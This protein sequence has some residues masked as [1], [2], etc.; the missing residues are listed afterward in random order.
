MSLTEQNIAD[1]LVSP[2]DLADEAIALVQ[3]WL[4]E[5]RDEP[6]DVSAQRLAGVLRDPHGLDF[7]VGFVDGVVRPEDLRVAARNLAALTP[8]IPGFLPLHLKAAIRLGAFA[9]PILPQVVVPAARMALRSMVRHLIVDATDRKL[10]DAISSI[11]GRGDGIR[12]NVNLLGEAILG[13]KEAARRLEGTRKLLARD[14]V[15]YVSIKVSSTVA[16]HTPWAFDAAVADAVSALRPLYRVAKETGTFLNLDMEEF[17]DLDLTLAVFETLLGEPE[18]HGVEAGIVLQAYLPDAL[19]AMIRLQEWTAARVASGGAPIKVRVVKGANLPMERVDADVHD[20]PLATWPSKQATDASYKAV[21]DYALRPEHTVNVRIGVAGHN[22]FDIALAWL[23]A[24]RRGVTAAGPS[25]QAG[26]EV[27]MLLGMATAQQT[28]VRRTV[29]SIL[30]YTPVVHPQEFDV[31]IAYLIR[32]LEEGAS[33]ENFMSA[34]FDLDTH[35]ALFARE[36]DRF[37]ASLADMPEGV[38]ASNRVQDRTA[39]AASAPTRGFRNTPDSDPAIEANRGWAA[40]IVARMQGSEL[41]RRTIADHTLTDEAALNELIQDAADAAAAWRALGAAGR[42]EILHRAGDVLEARRADLLEV[43]GAECGKVIEQSDPEV[44]EAIDFAHY[45]AEQALALEAVDG[46]TF[47]PVGVTVVA[48]PWNFPVAIPAGSTLAALAAGSAV[49]IKPAGLAERCGAVMVEALWE[50]G[51]PREVLKLVQVSEN[52]L[53]RQLLTHPAVERVVL[54]GAYE[55]AEL[56]RSFRPDL[57]LLAETSG[58]NAVIVTPSADLDLAAKDVAMSAF[59]HAGQKCSAASLV[60]LVGSVARSRRFRDQ[61]VDAVTSLEVGMPWDEASRV[62]PLIEPAQGKLLRALTSLEPGQRW[63]VEPQRLDADGMLWRPGIREG[64]QPGSEFHRTEYFGPVLGIMTAE[65]LDEAIDIVNAIEYGLTSGLHA[66]DSSEI[67]TWLARIEAGNVY[68]NRGTTGAIVQRQPFG[69]W[70]KSAVGAG[71]KAGGPHYLFGFGSWTDADASAP[72]TP[73]A[74]A[75]PALVAVPAADRDWLASA[76]ASDAAAWASEFSLARDVTGLESEQNV[77]RYASVPV[78]VRLEDASSSALVRVVAAGVRAGSAVT[79]SSA[80]ELPPAVRAWLEG[81]GVRSHVEDA[82]EWGR[83][84][85]RLARTG[86]RVRLL[87]GSARV[88]AEATGGSPSVAVYA[89]EVTRAGHVELLP[90]L[91]E[92]AVSITAHRFGTPR[93]YEVPPLVAA[94]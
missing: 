52:D 84:A 86:G 69:G 16:P 83:R 42:A 87:G 80:A 72:R 25:G 62:G 56:F 43:M 19:A 57:P 3:R 63:V 27:E 33:S 21:L 94:R 7:T 61:L 35:A 85:A 23:L 76:L 18:F 29:G 26:I 70:K 15:D 73:D 41:G 50:A 75:A 45:Y 46:A 47:T 13:K 37:L 2:H 91:R 81:V 39:P 78:T 5:S 89:G 51:V 24:E 66:L 71:T 38:P 30:L 88:V 49:V 6:V 90:F 60:V 59:G 22:L 8:L 92:Q 14:D 74:L 58:K 10:G 65:T 12:L 68:V 1:T 77:L 82:A 32:R 17:K 64:V 44:S 48:P 31:A 4:V 40:G 54:T 53:G 55:T 34:V 67:D 28:V 20:W 36:R 9:A 93:R 11:R 79:V